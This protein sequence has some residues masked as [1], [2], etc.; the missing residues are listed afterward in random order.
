MD[1]KKLIKIAVIILIVI[2]ALAILEISIRG[3][4]TA[5]NEYKNAKNEQK[6]EEIYKNS[7]EYKEEQLLE[8]VVS[9][10][11]KLLNKKDVDSIYELLNEDY[12]EYKFAGNKEE[13]ERYISKYF[14]S[15]EAEYELQTHDNLYGRYRCRFLMINNANYV[16]Y[17][18]LVTP[19]AD[20]T[21]DIIFDDF[22]TLTKK[23][24]ILSQK[25]DVK[26]SL[27]YV[28]KNGEKYIYVVEFENVGKATL[29]YNNE[30]VVLTNT[31]GNT[32]QFK[33]S[34]KNLTLKPNEKV[35]CE[36]TFAGE[37]I[38]LYN[39]DS[40]KINLQESTSN[41]SVSFP[42]YIEEY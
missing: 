1:R 28:I 9:E 24:N 41:I 19:K 29:E 16:S 30:S 27:K 17:K 37:Y 31:K 10:F 5:V 18:L 36:Y 6:N 7:E 26:Y 40:I 11:G 20:N 32:Y 8:K 39:H 34:D 4:N 33:P 25:G 42:L 15:G 35:K 23:D 12:K 22:D 3:I 21:Y 14:P 2:F 38:G 13:F